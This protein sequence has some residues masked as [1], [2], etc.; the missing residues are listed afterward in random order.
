MVSAAIRRKKAYPDAEVVFGFGELRREGNRV[1][2]IGEVRPL[3]VIEA[4][5][6]DW[7]RKAQAHKQPHHNRRRR[8]A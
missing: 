1:R 2:S 4:S 8:A 7:R 3:L 6:T 5:D